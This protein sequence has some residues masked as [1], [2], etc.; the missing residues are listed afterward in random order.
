LHLPRAAVIA[1]NNGA[2][3]EFRDSVG[4]T[5]STAAVWGVQRG[6]GL[7][8]TAA[9][10]GTGVIA[11]IGPRVDKANVG[12][13]TPDGNDRGQSSVWLPYVTNL[14][15]DTLVVKMERCAD[16]FSLV[17]NNTKF[18]NAIDGLM[19]QGDQAAWYKVLND[20]RVVVPPSPLRPITY[21]GIRSIGPDCDY[22]APCALSQSIYVHTG[23]YK[24][25]PEWST[26]F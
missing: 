25:Q 9:D 18:L 15:G 14:S 20:V 12:W 13:Q 16:G 21:W 17:P 4:S 22:G 10:D 3:V 2:G 7:W 24:K 5:I 6:S 11:N 26:Q 23:G 8:V 19:Q 1:V